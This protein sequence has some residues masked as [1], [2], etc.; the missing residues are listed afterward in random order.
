VQSAGNIVT[1][2]PNVHVNG[3]PAARAHVDTAKCDK[4][5]SSARILAEGSSTVHINGQPA[6]RVGDS[7]VCDGKISA[8]S[9][10]VFIGGGTDRTDTIEPEVP[11][12][13]HVALFG[14]G[15]V[16]GS[17]IATP[18]IA[19][20]AGFVGLAGGFAGAMVGGKLF[21]EGT[22]G[23]KLTAFGGAVLAGGLGGKG[24]R[25]FDTRYEIQAKGLGS[26]LGN[27]NINVKTPAAKFGEA[28]S[29]NYKATFF[30]AHPELKGEV[31]VHHAVEQQVQ[32]RYPGVV[33]DSELHSLENLR[34]IPKELNSELHLSFVRKEWNRFYKL[35]PTAT[36]SGLLDK[37]TEIDGIIGKKFLPPV[38]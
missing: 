25:W 29:N 8:G 38:K 16:A 10:N 27:I 11:L 21:G 14:A 7:T 19:V 22:D 3:L 34:G 20:A 2:S 33:K 18:V 12:I 28:K 32:I 4:H 23:Q 26:N 9:T 31:V 37:A 6:A 17:F 24:G 13:V 36:K 1:G 15:I 5:G 30:E 35:N